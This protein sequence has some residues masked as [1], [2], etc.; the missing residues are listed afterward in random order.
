[1]GVS[2]LHSENQLFLCPEL[3][4]PHIEGEWIRGS[5]SASVPNQTFGCGLVRLPPLC[6]DFPQGPGALAT[7]VAS[8]VSSFPS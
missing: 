6:L 5:F 1:M 7:S 8:P 2:N 4:L 3:D